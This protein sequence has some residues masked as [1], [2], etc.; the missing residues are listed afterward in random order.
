MND[1]AGV[2]AAPE[3]QAL[4]ESL[5]AFERETSNQ[6]V[7]AVFASLEGQSLEDFT[8]R[9]AESWKVGQKNKNN[10]VLLAV[11]MKD[12]KSRIEVGYGLEG[13]LPDGLCA[14]IL[15]NELAPHFKEGDYAGGLKA[16]VTAIQ[17]ATRGEYAAESKA[18]KWDA[19]TV[20]VLGF[21]LVFIVLFFPVFPFPIYVILCTTFFT[22]LMTHDLPLGW[23]IAVLPI[24]L[25]LEWI[26]QKW[27]APMFGVTI[28]KS[29][30]RGFSETYWGG[31]GGGSGGGGWSGGGGFSGGGGSFGGGG[32]SGGW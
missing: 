16:A 3:R 26:R 24:I 4:E 21:V 22:Y 29:R 30:K 13:V 9:L 11:F 7:I 18:F 2:L 14:R 10:G 17:Q 32:S 20:I 6:I 19:Q 1:N 23:W 5:A 28:H 8:W 12:R 15:R 27:I 25:I 31:F